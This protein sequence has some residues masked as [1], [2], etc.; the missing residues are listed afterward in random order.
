VG[1][2]E[3]V[4][5]TADIVLFAPVGGEMCVLLVKRAN[6]P[7]QGFWALPGG[8]V[9]RGETARE[10]AHRELKEETGVKLPTLNPVGFYDRPDRDPRG[11]FV[12]VAFSAVLMSAPEAIAGDDAAEVSWQP[13]RKLA[14][15][16]SDGLEL[17]FDHDVVVDDALYRASM[18]AAQAAPY[19]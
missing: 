16:A 6:M 3:T 1:D 12:S 19:A 15:H 13:I 7:F 9:D 5:L 10:A 17:A 11:R 4:T 18:G 8:K 14:D 2:D